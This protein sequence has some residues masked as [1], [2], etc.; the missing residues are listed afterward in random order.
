VKVIWRATAHADLLRIFDY[1]AHDNP[2]AAQRLARE[3]VAAGDSLEQFP[4][5]GRPGLLS[6]TRELV[7]VRPYIMVY[8]VTDIVTILRIWHSAQKRDR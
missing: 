6:G 4:D 5:R 1:I 7:I 3:L 8:E 2:L